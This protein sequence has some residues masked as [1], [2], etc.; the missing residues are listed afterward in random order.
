MTAPRLRPRKHPRQQRS[1]ETVAVILEATRR[2]L[3]QR[4]LYER[5]LA[6]L[7]EE[8]KKIRIGNGQHDGQQCGQRVVQHQTT[9]GSA[10]AANK[11]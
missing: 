1:Q 10:C 5:V 6:R 3:V 8:T 9:A 2:V 4:G 11:L 7:I